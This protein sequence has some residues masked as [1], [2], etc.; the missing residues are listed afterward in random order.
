VKLEEVEAEDVEVLGAFPEATEWAVEE[1]LDVGVCWLLL[2]VLLSQ[3][4]REMTPAEHRTLPLN[5]TTRM[6]HRPTA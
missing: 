3:L 5:S 4:V 1:G 6:V 2:V